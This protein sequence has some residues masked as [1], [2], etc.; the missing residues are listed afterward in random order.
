MFYSLHPWHRRSFNLDMAF[1]MLNFYIREQTSLLNLASSP[2][3]ILK[4]IVI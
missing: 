2:N 1:F 4:L 3:P